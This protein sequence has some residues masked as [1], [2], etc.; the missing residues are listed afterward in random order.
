V[1]VGRPRTWNG[2]K[3]S[4]HGEKHIFYCKTCGKKIERL[5]SQ[6]RFHMPKYCCRDCYNASKKLIEHGKWLGKEF[7]KLA[8]E[9]YREAK[10][11]VKKEGIK[12]LK[13]TAKM[14]DLCN[15]VKF[16]ELIKTKYPTP[17]DVVH[18][19]LS[20]KCDNLLLLIAK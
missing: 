12:I 18:R 4:T 8:L 14:N 7:G 20:K 11:K 1:K 15:F 10:E 6:C 16:K 9:F 13:K 5:I 2:Y 17:E 19:I 3:N